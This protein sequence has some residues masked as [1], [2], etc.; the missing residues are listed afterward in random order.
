LEVEL[1]ECVINGNTSF[2][3]RPY[4]FAE[5]FL[6]ITAN[7]EDDAVKSRLDGIK[8]R[9]VEKCFPRRTHRINLFQSA[10]A[11]AHSGSKD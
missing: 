1:L 5:I 6:D 7:D 8:Y 9:V 10:V 2:V 4:L 3:P 11:A